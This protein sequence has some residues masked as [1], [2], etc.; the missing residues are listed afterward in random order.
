MYGDIGVILC[1]K[2]R[3]NEKYGKLGMWEKKRNR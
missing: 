3:G 1:G 2:E